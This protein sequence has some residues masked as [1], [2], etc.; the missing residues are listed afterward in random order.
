[1]SQ[2]N[3]NLGTTERWISAL[4]GA[5]FTLAAIGGGGP[6]RRLAAAA[7]G[8]SL[9]TRSA[10]GY[11]A[12]K[13]AMTGDT[14]G[15]AD[16]D[17]LHTLYVSELQELRS[18][19]AQLQSLLRSLTGSFQSSALDQVLRGYATDIEARTSGLDAIIASLG[20]S[21]RGHTDRAMRAL[22][23]ETRRMTRVRSTH[24]RGAALVASLQRLIHFKIAGYGTAATY[25]TMLPRP[26]DAQL[27]HGYVERDK[28]VDNELTALAKAM[29]NPEALG[30][31]QPPQSEPSMAATP[32]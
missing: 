18:A 21:P 3:G 4:L 9:L 15:T 2:L 10:T 17:S 32:H 14:E 7:A 22:I 30:P 16:I 26:G 12:V 28:E 11:C 6:L 27:L 29:V 8:A 5:G 23:G 24:V 19:E 13:A 25:A 20:G 31:E 1:M